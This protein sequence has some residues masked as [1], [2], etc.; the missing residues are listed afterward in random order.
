LFEHSVTEEVIRRA[1]CPVLVAKAPAA[2][3]VPLAEAA[4]E[5]TPSEA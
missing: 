4:V 1:P 2:G 3:D 5:P